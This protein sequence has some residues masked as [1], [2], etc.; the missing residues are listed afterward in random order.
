MYLVLLTAFAVGG[1]TILGAVV[2]FFVRDLSAKLCN[3]TLGFATGIMLSAT[4]AGL[5]LPAMEYGGILA[6]ITVP[7]CVLAGAVGMDLLN[8]LTPK[9]CALGGIPQGEGESAERF[10]RVILLVVAMAIHNLP[11]GIASGVGFGT[12]N[13]AGALTVAGGIALQNLPEGAVVIASMRSV[14]IDRRRALVCD[15]FT[16]VIEIIGTVI[17]YFI[18]SVSSV[19]L[20][21]ALSLA[22]GSMLYVV[23]EEMIPEVRSESPSSGAVYALLFGFCLMLGMEGVIG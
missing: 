19:V 18:A 3:L 20:P 4:F 11:E 5:I 6:P 14:G 17:G 12:G 2:G 8:R 7:V 1:A 10:R 9:I 22:G 21:I 23:C 16:G 13:I 15:I